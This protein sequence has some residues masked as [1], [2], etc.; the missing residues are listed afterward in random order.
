MSEGLAEIRVG[1]RNVPSRSHIENSGHSH[2]AIHK[3]AAGFIPRA[4]PFSLKQIIDQAARIRQ[5]PA[6]VSDAG[7]DR[8]HHHK[9]INPAGG[10]DHIGHQRH[11]EIPHQAV[12][13]L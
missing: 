5:V 7:A 13:G 2:G 12:E 11:I 8:F 3:E 1:F 9:P 6:K 4:V 10:L